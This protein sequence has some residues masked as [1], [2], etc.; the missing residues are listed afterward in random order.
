MIEPDLEP[1]RGMRPPTLPDED[2][3]L[4]DVSEAD[5][6]PS[7]EREAPCAERSDGQVLLDLPPQLMRAL[8][9]LQA[10]IPKLMLAQSEADPGS[11]D[12]DARVK[13]AVRR[14]SISLDL[15]ER[16]LSRSASDLGD[17]AGG[18]VI[19]GAAGLDVSADRVL[20]DTQRLIEAI[21]AFL[22]SPDN[23]GS[24]ARLEALIEALPLPDRE[25]RAAPAELP[26]PAGPDGSGSDRAG[27]DRIESDRTGSVSS[28]AQ[29]QTPGPIVELHRFD[30]AEREWWRQRFRRLT[31]RVNLGLLLIL[32]IGAALLVL[33]VADS[34]LLPWSGLERGDMIS[35]ETPLPRGAAI[36]P[37]GEPT[38][39]P[40]VEPRAEM[41]RLSALLRHLG[42]S[43]DGLSALL[44]GWA[45]GPG[46]AIAGLQMRVLELEAEV[47][48]LNARVQSL[49]AE[50]A[51]PT[52]AMPSSLDSPGDVPDETASTEDGT[53]ES[54]VPLAQTLPDRPEV[55]TA[56][57]KEP[58]QPLRVG[59]R[60]VLD[61][62]R[63]GIQLAALRR[64][65]GALAFAERTGLNP[66]RLFI[67]SSGGW[68]V[69]VF[70]WFDDALR[71]REALA[72][73]SPSLLRQGP[74]VRLFEPASAVSAVRYREPGGT[75]NP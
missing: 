51:R 55:V 7:G 21:D 63:H 12:V 25:A 75:P 18:G 9:A 27:S 70:G 31:R 58:L 43:G 4:G 71:A 59:E 5:P 14:I 10:R 60:V 2:A 13:R 19:E 49:D 48:R 46:Q 66:D 32:S 8:A 33:R 56:V 62:A 20:V 74:M 1:S 69:V 50:L 30:E 57:I 24:R 34:R 40:G 67:A 68:F 47:I 35:T 11:A 16:G 37:M 17:R 29:A 28:G 36:P 54:G 6:G 44:E 22:E 23:A 3:P 45:S 15:I 26:D 73:L 38:L 52:A 39:D 42:V 53:A 64:E 61:A 41:T 65:E 72:G